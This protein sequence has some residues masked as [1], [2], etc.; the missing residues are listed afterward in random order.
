MGLFPA[1]FHRKSG[2]PPKEK[3][4]KVFEKTFSARAEAESPQF[5]EGK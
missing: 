4:R 3:V 1:L 5:F 2:L